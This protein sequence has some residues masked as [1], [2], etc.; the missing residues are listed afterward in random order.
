MAGNAELSIILR[1][2]DEASKQLAVV[3]QNLKSATETLRPLGIAATALGGAMLA[4]IGLSVKAALEERQSQALLANTLKNVGLAY[5]LVKDN[6]EDVIQKT[7]LKTGVTDEDQR[8]ALTRLIITTGNYSLSLKALPAAL[9]LAATSGQSLESATVALGKALMG[10]NEALI[11]M[12]IIIPEGLTGEAALAY[13]LGIIGGNAEAA[14]NPLEIMS[15]A[16]GEILDALGTTL[17]GDLDTFAEN[18]AEITTKVTDWIDQNPEL[19]RALTLVAIAVAILL[20][21]FGAFVLAAPGILAAGTIIG[22]G[23]FAALGPIGWVI[24][25][26]IALI[27]VIVLLIINWDKVKAAFSNNQWLNALANVFVDVANIVIF[28]INAIMK[29]QMMFS[30]LFGAITGKGFEAPQIPYIPLPKY[31]GGTG[32]SGT[33][34]A[35]VNVTINGW[36]GNDQDLANKIIAALALQGQRNAQTALGGLA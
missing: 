26:V 30:Y 28:I 18:V 19:T 33:S 29:F 20:V 16:L 27:A 22:S 23:M 36:V 4:G 2:R 7:M 8:G 31:T 14:A 1:L 15:A 12:G 11:R 32:T 9:D 25:G 3:T 10:N 24:L 17:L 13:V 21:L 5:D 34:T 6:L 35:P